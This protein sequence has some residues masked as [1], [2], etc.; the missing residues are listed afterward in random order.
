MAVTLAV[1]T[2]RLIRYLRDDSI[3]LAVSM[4]CATVLVPESRYYLETIRE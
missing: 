2:Q 1:S 3:E 4:M